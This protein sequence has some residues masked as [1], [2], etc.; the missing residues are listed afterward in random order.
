LCIFTPLKID[1]ATFR[2]FPHPE[3]I[4]VGGLAATGPGSSSSE[5]ID[6]GDARE[7]LEVVVSRID[8]VAVLQS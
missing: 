1:L 2:S 5:R 3:F 7:A 8:A 6:V 4:I